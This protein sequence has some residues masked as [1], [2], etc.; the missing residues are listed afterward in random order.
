LGG[1]D[2]SIKYNFFCRREWHRSGLR[3]RPVSNIEPPTGSAKAQL[4]AGLI[5]YYLNGILQKPLS[6]RNV[7]ATA[8]LGLP[9]TPGLARGIR[10]RGTSFYWSDHPHISSPAS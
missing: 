4:G 10:T 7:L 1:T 3:S 8:E 6:P 9:A 2:Y 5:D